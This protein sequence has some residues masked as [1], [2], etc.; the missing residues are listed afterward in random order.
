MKN[1]TKIRYS[2]LQHLDRKHQM[3]EIKKFAQ[4]FGESAP[5]N[6]ECGYGAWTFMIKLKPDV[7]LP[8][9]FQIVE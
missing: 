9:W 8:Q 3:I 5:Y 2:Y 7:V 6:I 4:E 1:A